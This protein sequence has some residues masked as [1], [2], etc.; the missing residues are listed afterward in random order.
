ML[1][2]DMNTRNLSEY[3][4]AENRGTSAREILGH[5]T[6]NKRYKSEIPCGHSSGDMALNFRLS[7]GLQKYYFDQYLLIDH[8]YLIRSNFQFARQTTE[9]QLL[10]L[11]DNFTSILSL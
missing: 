5:Y 1:Q 6:N 4:S 8:L 11:R 7:F 9:G 10:V 3:D 2:E